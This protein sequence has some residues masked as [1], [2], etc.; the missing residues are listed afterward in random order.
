MKKMNNDFL[1][2][3]FSVFPI[4]PSFIY[5]INRSGVRDIGI[6]SQPSRGR[7]AKKNESNN[8]FIRNVCMNG[9][10]KVIKRRSN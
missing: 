6:E 9:E 4:F 7:S 3:I 8:Q 10:R 1:M 2:Q 5:Y